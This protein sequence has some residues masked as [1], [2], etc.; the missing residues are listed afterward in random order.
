M[1]MVS[2]FYQY[3]STPSSLDSQRLLKKR[4]AQKVS[5]Y[6]DLVQSKGGS[7]EPIVIGSSGS[8]TTSAK[9]LLQV[10]CSSRDITDLNLVVVVMTFG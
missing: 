7:F 8:I 2:H 1:Y 5:K 9:K 3:L 10:I 4:E 6:G